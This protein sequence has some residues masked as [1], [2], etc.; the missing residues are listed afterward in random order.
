MED[1]EKKRGLGCGGCG[2][3][4]STINR[5][6]DDYIALGSPRL[7]LARAMGVIIAPYIMTVKATFLTTEAQVLPSKSFSDKVAQ[8]TLIDSVVAR[9][10]VGRP[11]PNP[12]Q[13]ISDYYN[14]YMDGI[15][16]TLD[17]QG[18][19]RYTVCPNFTPLSTLADIIKTGNGWPNGWLLTYQ[20]QI[21]MSFQSTFQ[22]PDFPTTVHVTFRAWTPT[23]EMFELMT[24]DEAIK[25][26][27]A[28]GY[29]FPSCYATSCR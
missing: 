26:L 14:Q 25:R 11:A 3:G 12:L 6:V 1:G 5:S 7:A 2:G 9:V 8:D 27:K 10:V 17:V 22:L 20:Q 21:M 28:C 24:T 13:P 15:E 23:G 29:D 16:A 19:P 4:S 18:A